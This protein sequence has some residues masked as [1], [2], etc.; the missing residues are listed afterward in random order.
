MFFRPLQAKRKAIKIIV[1]KSIL[2]DCLLNLTTR[3]TPPEKILSDLSPEVIAACTEPGLQSW[4]DPLDI[5]FEAGNNTLLVK[6]PHKFFVYHFQKNVFQLLKSVARKVLNDKVTVIFSTKTN[7]RVKKNIFAGNGSKH[8]HPLL[9]LT[10][11]TEKSHDVVYCDNT[12][13]TFI[14]NEKHKFVLDQIQN[15]IRSAANPVKDPLTSTHNIIVLCGASGTGK[16]HIL[17]SIKNELSSIFGDKLFFS[18][19]LSPSA[20]KKLEQ[21]FQKNLSDLQIVLIDDFQVVGQVENSMKLQEELCTALDS[22]ANEKRWMVIAGTGDAQNWDISANL[23]TIL[24]KQKWI[25][26]PKP[27]LDIRIRYLQQNCAQLAINPED[28]LLVARR[29]PDIHQLSLVLQELTVNP[30]EKNISKEKILSIL[31]HGEKNGSITVKNIVKTVCEYCNVEPV[32]ML[33]DKK[34]ANLVQARNLAM[35]LCRDLLGY[36][37]TSIGQIFGGRNHAT[38][39]HGIKKIK[40]LQ[41]NNNVVHTLVTELSKKCRQVHP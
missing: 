19:L 2:R 38:V 5:D 10:D 36:S 13:N 18:S 41:E 9:P 39:M 28:I 14:S 20:A 4:F 26:L 7:N 35:Y 17:H 12:F 23:M 30:N 16:T 34:M 1:T 21:I 15:F 22:F 27:D 24:K 6:L 3:D 37:Y 32:D 33:G 8:I 29:C 40:L 25:E 11:S 31:G